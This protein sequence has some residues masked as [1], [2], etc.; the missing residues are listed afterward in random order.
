MT[1]GAT[2]LLVLLGVYLIECVVAF[3]ATSVLFLRRADGW[4]THRPNLEVVAGMGAVGFA[5]PL[6]PFRSGFAVTG[7]PL[8]VTPRELGAYRA[9][10]YGALHPDWSR[11]ESVLAIDKVASVAARRATL[12]V[13]E[14]PFATC[15]TAREARWF[16]AW[17]E[18]LRRLPE[19]GREARIREALD[20]SMDPAR[21]AARV[22]ESE[23][24]LGPLRG[25]CHYGFLSLFVISPV[26]ALAFGFEGA[27]LPLLL[28]MLVNHVLI[29]GSAVR[30][31]RRLHPGERALAF[32]VFPALVPSPPMALR[33]VAPLQLPVCGEAHPF[34]FARHALGDD[35]LAA[36]AGDLLRDLTWPVGVEGVGEQ[37]LRVDAEARR[38]EAEQLARAC[39]AEGIDPVA[40]LDLP[41]ASDPE[42]SAVCPR[43]HAEYHAETTACSDCPGLPLVRR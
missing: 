31:F 8:S 23:E 19:A 39:Q 41:P 24:I 13:N 5:P 32:R 16:A 27:V 20:E 34:G 18:E 40:L 33:A 6:P 10:R 38:L 14:E 43:C 35:A 2:L 37:A 3:P 36:L 25:L 28:L 17:L 12:L 30:R 4:R 11:R 15:A 42:Y 9:L 22:E 21:V 29:V 7:W 1:I 26:V